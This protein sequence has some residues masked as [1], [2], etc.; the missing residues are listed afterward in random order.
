MVL[1]RLVSGLRYLPGG[2]SA[3]S[4]EAELAL[5]QLP[6]AGLMTLPAGQVRYY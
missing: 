1:Q 3:S 5:M 2:Q 6:V 4:V